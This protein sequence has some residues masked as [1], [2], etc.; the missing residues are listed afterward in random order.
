MQGKGGG[1]FYF[2]KRK[3]SS[4]KLMT[5]SGGSYPRIRVSS[6]KLQQPAQTQLRFFRGL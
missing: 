1:I 2:R 3:T 5:P 4:S 6:Q